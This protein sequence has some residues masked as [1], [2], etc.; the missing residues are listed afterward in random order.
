VAPDEIL[1]LCD[2]NDKGFLDCDP[3]EG[4][5]VRNFAIQTAKLAQVSD[6]IIYGDDSTDQRIIKSVAG[7]TASVQRKWKKHLEACGQ[8]PETYHTFVLTN[9]FEEVER[10]YPELVAVDSMGRITGQTMDFLQWERL[11]MCAMS[12][13]SEFSTGVYQGPSPG[14]NPVLACKDDE[15]FDILIETSDHAQMPDEDVLASKLDEMGESSLHLSFPSSGSILPPSRSHSEV[16]S[17]LTM[18]RFIY[19]VTHP[20]SIPAS[21]EDR[22]PDQGNLQIADSDG[23]VQM[24]DLSPAPSSTSSSTSVKPRKV[25]IHCADGYTES[26]LLAIAYFMYAEGVPV[27][28][29]WL[30][31]HCDK[32]R[33]FFAYPSDVAL[34]TAIQPRLLAESPANPA[35]VGPAPGWLSKLD[36]SLPSRI[37]PYMYLG[38][39]THANN[40]ELLREM[41]IKRILSIGE[42]VSWV[43][44]EHQK[45]SRDDLMMVD[46][47]QD[48]GIDPLTGEFERCLEFIGEW[49]HLIRVRFSGD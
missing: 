25:L 28:T 43:K 35:K 45:W 39:L 44:S 2:S 18:C 5:S 1:S 42:P 40:P 22:G 11:E 30:R 33:N 20:T 27:H 16:D 47:V 36:G 3:K 26:T 4:F 21:H 48:N 23:D 8:C 17:L 38:N 9:S 7:R 12:K 13:S 49:K 10:N 32:G 41:G 46:R 24:Q 19:A 29:A 34:L 37:L 6:I 14:A 15:E 31:M